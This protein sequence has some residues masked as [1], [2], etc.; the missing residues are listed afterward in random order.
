LTQ[1]VRES[2][3][4]IQS[5]LEGIPRTD[6]PSQYTTGA[7]ST[8]KHTDKAKVVEVLESEDEFEAFNLPLSLE[9]STLDLSLPFSPII[10]E[11]GIQRKPKSSLLDLIES[12]PRNDALGKAAR[13]KPPIRPF[14]LPSQVANLKRK[15]EP[16]RKKVMGAGQTLPLREDD[17]QK[18]SKQAKMG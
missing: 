3:L 12:Q 1:P 18:A 9:A 2:D 17:V 4:L 8:S 16:K 5:I 14:V 10:D 6:L 13:T 11:M 7:S 15:R